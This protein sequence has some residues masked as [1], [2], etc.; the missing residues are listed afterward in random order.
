MREKVLKKKNEMWENKK[1]KVW[2]TKVENKVWWMWIFFFFSFE[3]V[4]FN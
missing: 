4:M 2:K 1:K 3:F